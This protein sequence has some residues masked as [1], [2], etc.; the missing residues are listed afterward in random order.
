MSGSIPTLIKTL[1]HRPNSCYNYV[2]IAL[3]LGTKLHFYIHL[4]EN[5]SVFSMSWPESIEMLLY[6]KLNVMSSTFL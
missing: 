3:N 1:I 2:I 6:Y 4:Q 5:I